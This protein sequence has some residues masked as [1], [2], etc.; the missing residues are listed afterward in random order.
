MAGPIYAEKTRIRDSHDYV[1]V[2]GLPFTGT[3]ALLSL[4]STSPH[5]ANLCAAEGSAMMCEGTGSL[6]TEKLIPETC[7]CH[8]TRWDPQYPADWNEALRV[9]SRTWNMSKQ[10]LIDKSPPNSVK[11]QRITMDLAREGKFPSFIVLSR[12]PCYLNKTQR[13]DEASERGRQM[14]A[15]FQ[16]MPRK[17]VL[18]IQ[19]EEIIADPYRAAAKILKFLPQLDH[20]DPTVDGLRVDSRVDAVEDKMKQQPVMR[21]KD[22]S[23]I[24]YI[25]SNYPMSWPQGGPGTGWSEYMRTFGYEFATS[26]GAV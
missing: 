19:Y 1:F 15:D 25:E 6:I 9:Y 8:K 10:I 21:G 18:H 7:P 13:D 5:V 16:Q 26:A 24:E 4:L 17:S 3:T 22:K 20:L 14:A 2:I 23:L 11:M 12:S